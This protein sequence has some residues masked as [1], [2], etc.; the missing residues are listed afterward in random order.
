MKEQ[1]ELE[2]RPRVT[3]DARTME[4]LPMTIVSIMGHLPKAV[5]GLAG[6]N[7]L[8]MTELRIWGHLKPFQSPK[9]MS[10]RN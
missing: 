3:G 7:L 1:T 5:V 6:P 2:W 4:H 8:Q 10:V 9:S